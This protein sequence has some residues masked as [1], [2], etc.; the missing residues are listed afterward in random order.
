MRR[1]LS[2]VAMAMLAFMAGPTNAQV[3]LRG[4]VKDGHNEEAIPYASVEMLP[5]R[6]GVITDSLGMFLLNTAGLKVDSVVISYVGYAR[7]ALP[8]TA[9]TPNERLNISLDR[10]VSKTVFVKMKVNWGLIL[11]RKVVRH[12]PQNDKTRFDSYGYEIHN[13]LE[14]DLNRVHKEKLAD[15]RLMKEFTFIL[16]NI[17][18]S[19]GTAILP[20]FLTETLSDYYYQRKPMRRR[21]VIKA[22][23]TN[24]INNESVTKNLGNMYQ[25][26]NVYANFIPVFDKLFISPLS[27]NGDAFYNY[28]VPDTVVDNGRRFFH[29]TFSP[30]RKGESTFDGDAW[31]HDSTFAVQRIQLKITGNSPVNFVENLSI[32]QDFR[33]LNDSLWFL[34]KDKFIADIYP[35]GKEK[36]G[37]KGRKTTTYRNIEINTPNVAL[38]LSKNTLSEEV[39]V[40]PTAE[41]Q[42]DSFWQTKRHEVLS[43]SEAGVYK[44]IDTLQQMPLFKAYTNT[45]TFLTTG[46]KPI[47]NYEIGPWFNWITANAWEGF[48]MRFDLGTRPGFNKKMYFHGYLAYGFADQ[49][50]KGKLEGYYFLRKN[51]RHYIHVSYLNDLDNGQNYYDEVSLDN[52]FSLAVRKQGIPMKFMKVQMEELEYFN[53]TANGWSAKVELRRKRFTPLL[54]LPLKENFTNGSGQPINNF[55]SSIRVKFAYLERFLDGNYLRTSLGSEFPIV[56]L[57]YG[58]GWAGV[59]GSGYNYH[60]LDFRVNDFRKIPPVGTLDYSV[61]MGK[62]FGTLP[63][64][65]LNVAPGNEIY[66]YN[67]YAFNLMSRFEYI[68]DQYIGAALEHNIGPGLFKYLGLTRRLKLRQFWNLKTL[69]GNL[70]E[71]NRQ[72]NFVDGHPF[73][74]LRG[75]LYAEVGTG[76]DNIL[77]VLRL[78]LVW[79][80]RPLPLPQVRA[81]RF[82]V[83]G[84]FRVSF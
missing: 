12:K 2:F 84:S 35:I 83:F 70:T 52:I 60:K 18:T 75:K 10:E 22:S 46:Y 37:M 45:L 64:M 31:V 48:R 53:S 51:P 30:K 50:F 81:S 66:Y 59:M 55:E 15:R 5:A 79:R 63:Y 47:G 42:P 36:F 68:T 57:R 49:K 74:D 82:G 7:K 61:Y 39:Q 58:K 44:M 80:L 3:L 76:I 23:K 13:K 54:N 33:Q 72:L 1:V 16:D 17:D 6:R 29:W 26:V 41:Q 65:L 69:A 4:Q 73:A 9:F 8:I 38:Q 32:Y 21:E 14:L 28:G 43:K 34:S 71:A 56:E 24:G 27:D 40:L 25:N 77:K 78:D 67:K 20:V 19:E 62:I 11:W